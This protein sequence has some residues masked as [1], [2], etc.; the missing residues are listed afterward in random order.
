[1]RYRAG[2]AASVI[3]GLLVL[4]AFAGPQNAGSG[5]VLVNLDARNASA[6]TETWL[7]QGTLGPFARIG[8]PKVV[9]LGGVKAVLFDGKR[10][11]YRGPVSIP[12][13]EGSAPRT[14]AVWAWNP[15]IDAPEETV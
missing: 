15:R 7:N 11:A 10:D 9:T 5:E 4:A 6:G 1:M 8:E 13:L 2:W 12:A 3:M 14:I